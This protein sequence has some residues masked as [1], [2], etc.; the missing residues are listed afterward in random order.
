MRFTELFT[1][2][3]RPQ[4]GLIGVE[5]AALAYL[6]FTLLLMYV[7]SDGLYRPEEMLW[8]RLRVVVL[9]AVMWAVYRLAPCRMTMFLRVFCQVALLAWWYP[10]TYSLNRSLPNFD[11]LFVKLDQAIFGCQPALLFSQ[12]FPSPIVS[13][14]M[15][16]GY[17]AYYP[18][19]ALTLLWYFFGGYREFERA[20]FIVMASFFCYYVI[21]DIC[22]AA[23]PTYYY[24]YA[25]LDHIANGVFPGVGDYFMYHTGSL[26]S[27]GYRD[28]LFYNLVECAKEAGERPTAAFPSSHVGVSTICMLLAWHYKRRYRGATLL[29]ILAPFYVFLCMATVYIQAH[30]AVDVLGG[31]VTGVAFYALFLWLTGK[32]NGLKLPRDRRW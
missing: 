13:E 30:Y 32:W 16:M 25:G 27:P 20:A 26:P 18:M 4:K 19:I 28:G 11:T 9:M 23:G 7:L 6:V 12:L 31:W 24:G 21:F 17:F 8:G 15:D 2:E 22:P 10:D 3:K 5:W 29:R 1:I 14:L